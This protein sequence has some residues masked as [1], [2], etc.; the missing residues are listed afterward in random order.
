[1]KVSPTA[2]GSAVDPNPVE[3]VRGPTKHELQPDT[4]ARITSDCDAM[5][6]PSIKLP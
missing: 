5:R 4:M 2:V 6:S 3:L 1:M